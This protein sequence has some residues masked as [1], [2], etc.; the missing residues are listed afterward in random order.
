MPFIL[1]SEFND[2]YLLCFLFVTILTNAIITKIEIAAPDIQ[3]HVSEYQILFCS[4]VF[5]AVL[6]IGALLLS[7]AILIKFINSNS[8]NIDKFIF[9]SGLNNFF[10]VGVI[11]I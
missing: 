1:T 10:M 5:S 7:C 11:L 6:E 3:T 9:H 2:P 4:L 8:N